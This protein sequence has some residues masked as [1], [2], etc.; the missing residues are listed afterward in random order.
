MK[1]S[2]DEG[3]GVLLANLEKWLLVS[4]LLI[5]L[6][7]LFCRIYLEVDVRYKHAKLGVVL[8]E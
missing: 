3:R 4:S 6:E 5:A 8:L 1:P 7:K 2:T